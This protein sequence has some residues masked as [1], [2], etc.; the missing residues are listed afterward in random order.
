MTFELVLTL[1]VILYTIL[2]YIIYYIIH[3]HIHILLYL[4]LHSSH[5]LIYSSQ[6]PHLFSPFHHSFP[7]SLLLSSSPQYSFYTCRYFHN[8]IY[9]LY[10]TL[11]FFCSIFY[12][13][14]LFPPLFSPSSFS[15]LPSSLHLPNLSFFLPHSC[16]S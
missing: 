15:S 5:L 7:Y 9:I 13:N 8:L 16:P 6:S 1:G 4:I 11:L 14:L 3:I 12:P 2:L 10:Y